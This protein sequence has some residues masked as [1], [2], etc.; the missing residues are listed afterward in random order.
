M[1]RLTLLTILSVL[2]PRISAADTTTSTT[3]TPTPTVDAAPAPAAPPTAEKAET[4]TPT[5]A[6]TVE[7]PVEDAFYKA[8]G[9]RVAA[10]TFE[11]T[12]RV[13]GE[14]Q[15][16]PR[17]MANSGRDFV[18]GGSTGRIT[19]RARLGVVAAHPDGWALHVQ[20]QDIRIWGEEADT[21]GDYSAAGFDIHQAYA[22][23]PIGD[24]FRL[25]LGRQEISFDNQRLVGAV[26]WAQRARAFDAVRGTLSVS[27]IVA[28]VFYAKL[29]ESD[30][31]PDGQ[32][33]ADRE[34]EA[35]FGG[36][37]ASY[38]F[39]PGHT[40]ALSYLLLSNRAIDVTRHTLGGIASGVVSGIGY[41]A[42]FYAQ[43]GKLGGENLF[44]WMAAGSVGYTLPIES[45]LAF[46]A[47]A[48]VLSGDGTATGTF[49]TLFAT[50][51]KFYGEMDFFLAI[52]A[53]TQN[54]GLMD[55]GGKVSLAPVNKVTASLDI[56][57]LRTVEGADAFGTELDLRVNFKPFPIVTI[58]A[59]YGLLLPASG[60]EARIGAAAGTDLEL[61]HMF[62]STVNLAI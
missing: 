1:K 44:A 42:E 5:S 50:N 22:R 20:T 55:F 38:A 3:T 52:P 51:H 60:F 32:I 59:V 33:P 26:D 27:G 49:D 6:S 14:L 15:Y 8:L 16:R 40:A 43:F 58:D 46:L 54:R 48:E 36:A 62:F 53:H 34:K 30:A 24:L 17:F 31:D 37:H 11:N 19:Q 45:K 10:Y 23:L 39:L 21:L 41:S 18:S 61:E 12:W 4:P 9:S 2:A 35:D 28:D 29:L 57:H 47:R 25:T 56:H 13:V 7:A